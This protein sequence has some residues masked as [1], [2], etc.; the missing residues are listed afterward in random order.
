MSPPEMTGL[1]SSPEKN[2]TRLLGRSSM[3]SSVGAEV[4]AKNRQFKYGRLGEESSPSSQERED[5]PGQRDEGGGASGHA[6]PHR[7]APG[8]GGARPLSYKSMPDLQTKANQHGREDSLIDLTVTVS[9]GEGRLYS[10]TGMTGAVSTSSLLDQS[11]GEMEENSFNTTV[12]TYQNEDS[13]QDD[14]NDTMV[15]RSTNASYMNQMDLETEEVTSM[16]TGRSST[17]GHDSSFNSLPPGETYHLPPDEDDPFDTSRIIIN[18]NLSISRGSSNPNTSQGSDQNNYGHMD[19]QM[20]NL[21]VDQQTTIINSL[22]SLTVSAPT[23]PG[24]G[25]S[26]PPSIISQLL[27]SQ[28]STASNS[29]QPLF[30]PPPNR[31]D[32]HANKEKFSDPRYGIPSPSPPRHRRAVS[33]MSEADTFLPPLAS[34]FSPPAFNPYDI[35]LGS[36]EAIAGLDS[37]AP[38]TGGNHKTEQSRDMAFSWLEDKMGDLKVGSQ[39][40]PSQDMGM[41]QQQVFQFPSVSQTVIQDNSQMR[42]KSEEQERIREENEHKHKEERR[43]MEEEE[44]KR[45]EEERKLQEEMVRQQEALRKQYQQQQKMKEQEYQR[46]QKLL[47]EQQQMQLAREQQQQM[48]LQQQMARQQREKE[49]ERKNLQKI[50]KHR[51]EQQE[52]AASNSQ[53]ARG[54]ATSQAATV[55]DGQVAHSSQP[56]DVFHFPQVST[57]STAGETLPT[58]SI[59][60]NFLKDLEKNLGANEAMANM[61]GPHPPPTPSAKVA[62]IPLLQPPPP[63]HKNPRASPSQQTSPQAPAGRQR[64]S[65][66]QDLGSGSAQQVRPGSSN[67]S[68]R[69]GSSSSNRP[70]SRGS[71]SSRPPGSSGT[72]PAGAVGSRPPSTG[73]DLGR[74][75]DKNRTAHVR[76]FQHNEAG[77]MGDVMG[78]SSGWRPLSTASNQQEGRV[79]LLAGQRSQLGRYMEGPT[80]TGMGREQEIYGSRNTGRTSNAMEINKIAQCS[81]MVPGM[82]G[83]EIRSVLEAVNWDTSIAVKNLKID[84][85]YR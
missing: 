79:D 49:M 63:S 56:S 76:P 48:M 43:R 1:E 20:P 37:P 18:P 61:L 72:R 44:N 23:N 62:N 47:Q 15:N 59:D 12:P 10:N 45:K 9:P 68:G 42:S 33:T 54:V 58:Y 26:G 16:Q 70:S 53:S 19:R 55:A 28:P 24:D 35:V 39:I 50:M 22:S 21:T 57:L 3:R 75:P 66:R 34:P 52:A 14:L 65:P 2:N 13:F 29:P 81:K 64:T 78:A 74:T 32:I 6:Q 25:T 80:E 41:M 77:R 69:P 36:N 30:T 60:K 5:P 11:I 27:A 38:Y 8:W 4:M 46:Q 31:R 67:S 82:S 84:K 71:S 17:P 51:Q 40:L 83:S 7:P 73:P 85:L